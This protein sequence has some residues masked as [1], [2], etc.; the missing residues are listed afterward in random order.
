MA[1]SIIIAPLLVRQNGVKH[2]KWQDLNGTWKIDS[3]AVLLTTLAKHRSH[4]PA[5]RMSLNSHY[6]HAE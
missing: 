4:A 3:S 1:M 6:K 2:P 5:I